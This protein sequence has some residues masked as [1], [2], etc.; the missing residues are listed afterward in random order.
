MKKDSF[1][2]EVVAQSEVLYRDRLATDWTVR[3]S[4][5]GRG[6]IFC[7]HPDRPWGPPNLL[8]KGYRVPFQGIKRPGCGDDH[9]PP[10]SAEVEEKAELYLHSSSG[11]TLPVLGVYLP[12]LLPYRGISVQ[13]LGYVKTFKPHSRLHKASRHESY[14]YWKVLTH[15]WISF[16]L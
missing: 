15:F 7:T 11:S 6:E 16:T 12:Y 8:Y 5:T 1:F 10:F 2:V 13:L 9:P 14:V 4:N 3:G